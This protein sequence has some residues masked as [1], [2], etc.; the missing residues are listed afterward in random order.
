[1]IIIQKDKFQC[2]CRNCNGRYVRYE[3]K[4]NEHI[5]YMTNKEEVDH[6][7]WHMYKCNVCTHMC[8]IRDD[9]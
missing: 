6:E 2:C 5:I 8:E 7:G 9:K 1:V 3:P 4:E